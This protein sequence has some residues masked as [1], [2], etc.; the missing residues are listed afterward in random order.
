MKAGM[1]MSDTKKE[2]FVP[3]CYLENFATD[4]L[5]VDL[6]DKWK[7]EPR[8]NQRIINVAMENE[9]YDMDLAELLKLLEPEEYDRVKE[10][11]KAIV[12]DIGLMKES[13]EK[14]HSFAQLENAESYTEI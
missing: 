3:R 13:I 2:H 10:D 12:G 1:L 7:V 9:F 14:Q 4:R 11:L 6:F 5:T 8:R